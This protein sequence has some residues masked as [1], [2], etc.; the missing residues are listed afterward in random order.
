[1]ANPKKKFIPPPKK[2]IPLIYV[3][4]S[5]PDGSLF[6]FRVYTNGIPEQVLRSV[7]N[8]AALKNLFVTPDKLSSAML[9]VKAQGHPLYLC[10]RQ[11]ENELLSNKEDR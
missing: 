8:K 3:G 11:I 7:K 5:F 10:N 4:T 6:R 1:M 2:N 9:N